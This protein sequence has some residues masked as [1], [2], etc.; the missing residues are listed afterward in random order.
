[1]AHRDHI[2]WL[3]GAALILQTALVIVL[4]SVPI[5]A[6]SA[7]ASEAPRHSHPGIDPVCASV[8]DAANSGKLPTMIVAGATLSEEEAGRNFPDMPGALQSY[9]EVDLNGDGEPERV[10]FFASSYVD[11]GV[12][13]VSA[14]TGIHANVDVLQQDEASSIL[15]MIRVDSQ[16]FLLSGEPPT[17]LYDLG[18]DYRVRRRCLFRRDDLQA[19]LTVAEDP[20]VCTAYQSDMLSPV[21]FDRMHVLGP[22]DRT[23]YPQTHPAEG[24]ARVDI[25][26][27]GVVDNVVRLQYSGLRGPLCGDFFAVTDATRTRLI[28]S[29][30]NELLARMPC[31]AAQRLLTFQ[32]RTYIGI[33]E[34]DTKWSLVTLRA[35]AWHRVCVREA[36]PRI[37]ALSPREEVEARADGENPWEYAL[38]KSPDARA[39]V[40]A[41][42]EGGRDVNEAI[43]DDGSPLG[44]AVWARRYDIVELL[45]AHGARSDPRG[46]FRDALAQ[47][48]SQKDP[49]LVALLIQHGA[50][51]SQ[52]ALARVTCE[53]ELLGFLDLFG[54]GGLLAAGTVT[55]LAP[56]RVNRDQ[57]PNTA[58]GSQIFITAGP[59]SG[60]FQVGGDP[61]KHD[62]HGTTYG[63]VKEE[64]TLG[65]HARRCGNLDA[66]PIIERY[67]KRP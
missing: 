48:V 3:R 32:G 56:Q 5:P 44:R 59:E 64:I 23:R 19:S 8:A 60:T 20:T 38:S 50:P 7:I 53:K 58:R 30:L 6:L 47:A 1:M 37:R 40:Q 35:G 39:D 26:N 16:P 15:T 9:Y 2:V 51:A 14:R 18:Q 34:T 33:Q 21:A 27:D 24:L 22:L 61:T 57:L 41:L 42:V 29:P 55:V 28:D 45:L 54:Q 36:C 49:R 10:G 31:A 4:L 62:P 65:E 25:D 43:G 12:E 67:Q 13:I 17:A 52:V 66:I 11:G 46:F 63:L